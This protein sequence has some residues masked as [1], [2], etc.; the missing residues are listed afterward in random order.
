ME[1]MTLKAALNVFVLLMLVMTF[2][3]VPRKNVS[4]FNEV[5]LETFGAAL[6]QKP[7]ALGLREK[8]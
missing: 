6:L 4:S 7:V 3:G 2:V 8:E 1:G 5:H